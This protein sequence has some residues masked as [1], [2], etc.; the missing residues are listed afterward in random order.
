MK[1]EWNLGSWFGAQLG[2]TA[3]I[4]IASV[5]TV[6]R[7]FRTGALVFAVFLVPNIVGTV[8]WRRREH[9]SCSIALQVLLPAIGVCGLLAVYILDRTNHWLAIQSGGSV[10]AP[11]GYAI[12]ILVVALLMVVMHAR[13]GRDTSSSVR[14]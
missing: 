2:S 12:I 5:L 3:W 7:D 13:Y 10:S 14:P 1:L 9:L 6:A 4:L 11:W 8:L